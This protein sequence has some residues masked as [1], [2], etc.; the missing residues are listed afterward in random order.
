MLKKKLARILWGLA[1]KMR[2][3]AVHIDPNRERSKQFV[4]CAAH[5]N[6][7]SGRITAG[8]RHFDGIVHETNKSRAEGQTD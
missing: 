8:A 1:T 4:V 2:I 7:R 5:R 3:L 6:R